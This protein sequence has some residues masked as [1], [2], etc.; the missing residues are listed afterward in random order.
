MLLWDPLHFSLFRKRLVESLVQRLHA[1]H[2]PLVARA[3]LDDLWVL[4]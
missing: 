3:A 2:H 1:P 4:L